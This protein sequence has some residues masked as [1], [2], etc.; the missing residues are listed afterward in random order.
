MLATCLLVLATLEVAAPSTHMLEKGRVRIV[1]DGRWQENPTFRR[2][3]RRFFQLPDGHTILWIIVLN[4]QSVEACVARV[5]F[6]LKRVPP[7]DNRDACVL[8]RTEKIDRIVTIDPTV[9]LDRIA[10][11]ADI[12]VHARLIW[13]MPPREATTTWL[14]E[15]A[16]ALIADVEVDGTSLGAIARLVETR[17]PGNDFDLLERAK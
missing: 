6:R 13:R 5:P 3:N 8:S 15:Q 17:T 9:A 14:V 16:N 4:N 12:T 7:H 1:V 10:Q 2:D 11:R